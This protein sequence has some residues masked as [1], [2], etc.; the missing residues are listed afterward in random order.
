MTNAEVAEL[1]EEIARFMELSGENHFKTRS[2]TNGA[3]VLE[4]LDENII[5]VVKEKRLREL[6]G[7][8][9]ALAEKIE[10]FV[11]SGHLPYLD[12][13]RSK[14]PE[15]I[16]ELFQ[17]PNLG[18]KRIKVLYEVLEIA[19]LDA[20][21]K[22]ADAGK[23]AEL[24]GFGEKMQVK[25]LEGI[26]FA[27]EHAN[28]HL[29]S[30]A[31]AVIDFM[32]SWLR[33]EPS[34]TNLSCAGSYR[35]CKEL[36]K[37][38]DLVASAPDPQKVMQHFVAAPGIKRVT[39]KGNTK[40]SVVWETGINVDLRVVSENEFPFALLHF[41][42]SKEHNVV[43]RRLAN[44]RNLKLNEYGLF[45]DKEL[46]VSCKDET[47]IYKQLDLPYI[48]PELREDLGEFELNKTPELIT[49]EEILGVIHCHTT[50]SDGKDSLGAM[51]AA[52]QA[53]KYKYIH[54]SDHSQSAAY[55]GGL[56][57]DAIEKQH[58]EIDAINS[59][60][61]D[62]RVLKGIES[63]IRTDGSL[64]YEDDILKRFDLIIASVHN[65]LDMNIDEATNRLVK[66]IENPFT[67][68]LGH[69]T[70]RLLLSRQGYP[71]DFDKVFDACV[72]NKVAV[73]I[74]AN[75]RR[76]D[77]DWRHIRRGKD[78]GVKFSIGPDAHHVAAIDNIAY[79]VGI[80]RKGWLE[81]SDVLNAMTAE[82]ILAWAKK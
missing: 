40:S 55:A 2:Y 11:V 25:I 43:L 80:A 37:D 24:K 26:E 51:V 1:L 17:I 38:V 50:Y 52:A 9:E 68:I 19:S 81:K 18:P 16:H 33:K 34:I 23:I 74:N 27:K 64:D 5:D 72:A 60:L 69:L 15:S 42:G 31:K 46:L 56:K 62:F 45:S 28:Q 29:L 65:K 71:L 53:R 67:H 13:L 57:I 59:K 73:E 44:E 61:K 4:Q 76:L 3:R 82:E 54:I 30:E 58:K 49:F 21:K 47:A 12:D 77:I 66:A 39:G 7:I 35:R 32:L 22:A 20:L 78:K 41:T 75:C 14:F 6:P 79:G 8:G 10:T 63:D 70:G 36:V 48:P